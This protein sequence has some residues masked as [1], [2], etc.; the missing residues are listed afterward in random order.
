MNRKSLYFTQPETIEIRQET[1]T[2]PGRD[3]LLVETQ[4]SAISA[5]TELLLYHGKIPE[6][7]PQDPSLE[8]YSGTFEFPVKYG[9]ATIGKVVDVGR[10]VAPTW[11][12]QTVFSFHPHESHFLATESELVPVPEN[13]AVEDAL[14]LPNME[15]AVSFM[16]DAR[17]II[18][19][20]VAVLGQGVIGLLT[21]AL[22]QRFPLGKIITFDL[23][24]NRREKSLELGATASFDPSRNNIEKSIGSHFSSDGEFI[25]ADVI[26]ELS[27]SPD[28]LNLALQ[29]AGFESRILVGSWYGSRTANLHL[30]E[31]FHRDHIRMISSQVSRISSQFSGR[32]TKSR[33]FETVIK[34]LN[35]IN[36]ST[37]IT[38][39]VSFENADR[40]YQLLD[41]QPDEAIQVI[42]E[43]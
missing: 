34:M 20:S 4:L 5:G 14:F 24:E 29:I 13:L 33:R 16:M 3:Q 12:G 1:L 43:Y 21:T 42:L 38:H 31:S 2:K 7:M 17:P 15:S 30:G 11:I 10:T 40:A 25:G 36:P 18:G 19:E 26:F 6:N 39:R 22:L 37:L 9:Y 27:G 32:W 35:E 28:V 23:F 41:D 8:A